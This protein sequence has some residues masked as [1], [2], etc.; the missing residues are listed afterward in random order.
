MQAWLN[1]IG[2]ELHKGFSPLFNP[3]TPAEYKVIAKTKLLDRLKWVDEELAGKKY[4]MG[5]A[6]T[7]ADPYLFTVA[8][9]APRVAVDLAPFANINAFCERVAA[10]PAA[11]A[12]MREEG[13]LK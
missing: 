10:R 2:T 3:A 1:F 5:D 9:W 13:L 12:A 11:Q 8:S 4:L 6:F 7:V